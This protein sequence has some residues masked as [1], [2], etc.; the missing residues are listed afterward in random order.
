MTAD[1][2]IDLLTSIHPLDRVPRAGYLL[3]GVTEPESVAAHSF[4]VVLLVMLYTDAYP[5][6]FDK[7]RALSMAV[8]HDLSES[9]TM[10]IPMPAGDAA[11]KREKSMTEQ[12]VIERLFTN[13]GA[14]YGRLH[15][16]LLER[17][18]PEARLV[19]ALDKAQMMVKVLCYEAEGRGR[20]EEFW[21][22]PGNFDDGGFSF[23]R[24]LYEAVSAAAGREPPHAD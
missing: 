17:G 1:A 15:R 21:R 11:F 6:L 24:E 10:D 5:E 18:T 7:E 19:R 14:G 22:N 8:I 13:F 20:L 16:D 12:R 2:I 23:I 9:E 4:S 3:R